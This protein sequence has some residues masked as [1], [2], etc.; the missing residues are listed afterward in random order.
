MPLT[1]LSA[2]SYDAVTGGDG[3]VLVACWAPWC[4]S[5]RSFEPVYAAASKRHADV[6]FARLDTSQNDSLVSELGLQH[7]PTLQLYRDG[8]LLFQ[9]PGT[10]DGEQLDGIVAQ[11]ASLD[12]DQVR[13]QIAASAADE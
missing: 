10:F 3:I 11:A 12:M 2:S 1:D 8:V 9:K 7:V 13:A 6:V 5:C 4:G